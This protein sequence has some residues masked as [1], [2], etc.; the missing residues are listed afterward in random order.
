MCEYVVY[1]TTEL[2]SLLRLMCLQNPSVYSELRI[3]ADDINVIVFY[4]LF[5]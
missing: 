3:V 1:T 2:I 5:S 4:T